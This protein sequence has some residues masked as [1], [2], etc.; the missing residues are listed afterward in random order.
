MISQEKALE[1]IKGLGIRPKPEKADILD[2]L[3]CVLSEDIKAPQD[4]PAYDNSAMDGYAVRSDDLIGATPLKP[5]CLDLIE[6]DV[7]AGSEKKVRVSKGQCVSIMTGGKI[8]GGSDTVVMQEDTFGEKK[9][10]CFIKE[11]PKGC[12]TRKK[13]E[14]I[15]EGSVVL[16]A[17]K[18]IS[19]ADIGVMAS[20]GYTSAPIYRRPLVGII[21]TGDELIEASEKLSAPKVR[22]SNSYSLA[23]QVI[24]AGARY[25]RY[26][27]IKDDKTLLDRHIRQALEETDIL[28]VSGGISVGK[29]DYIK[30]IISGI[31][32]ELLFWRVR[33][34]PGKPLAV[35]KYKD[36]VVFALPGNPVSSMVCFYVYVASLISDLMGLKVPLYKTITAKA[37]EEIRHKKGRTEFIRVV[38]EKKGPLNYISKT[39]PQGSGILTSLAGA[40]GIAIVPE[41]FGDVPEGTEL[42]VILIKE[43]K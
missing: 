15:K 36:K 10:I 42:K 28:L 5:V 35:F 11:I 20:L 38:L 40:D 34:K 41:D 25:K 17:K 18:R 22:D 4:I 24:E 7:S 2:C 14:D 12:N 6:G 3:G 21:S 32:A 8:P 43:Q 13:G 1:T 37:R 29:Y 39:G 26:G 27:I 30:D 31:G 23:A 9:R 19:P 33:Q 16:K